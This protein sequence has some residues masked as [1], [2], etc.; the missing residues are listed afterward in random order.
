MYLQATTP[1][2]PSLLPSFILHND[3]LSFIRCPSILSRTRCLYLLSPSMHISPRHHSP[4]SI[5]A[6]ILRTVLHNAVLHN[7]LSSYPPSYGLPHNSDATAYSCYPLTFLYWTHC[8]CHSSSLP[9]PLL[10]YADPGARWRSGWERNALKVWVRGVRKKTCFVNLK[11]R[12]PTI[13][14]SI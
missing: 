12:N 10:I 13:A 14:I 8:A 5:T 11:A 3:I 4:H 1:L 6:P 2:T 9:F 7:L